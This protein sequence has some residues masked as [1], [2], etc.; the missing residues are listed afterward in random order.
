MLGRRIGGREHVDTLASKVA[1]GFTN[2]EGRF[3][4]D[5][6]LFRAERFTVEAGPIFPIVGPGL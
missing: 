2:G 1:L 4:L 6:D 5:G 3:V